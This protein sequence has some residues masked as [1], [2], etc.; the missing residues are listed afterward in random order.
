MS[1]D[2]QDPPA[3]TAASLV[4]GILEDLQRL[5]QQQLLLT[6]RCVSTRTTLPNTVD[7]TLQY[8]RGRDIPI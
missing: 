4:S 8:S 1:A 7:Q 6:R 3:Q 2:I 5:V